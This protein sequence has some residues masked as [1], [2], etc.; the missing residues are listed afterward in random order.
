MRRWR[1]RTRRRCS[2]R[3]A[4]RVRG[5]ASG[6]ASHRCRRNGEIRHTPAAARWLRRRFY[7]AGGCPG[8]AEMAYGTSRSPGRQGSS[9]PALFVALAKQQVS[10]PSPSTGSPARLR[11]W[12]PTTRKTRRSWPRMIPGRAD[13]LAQRSLRTSRGIGGRSGRPSRESKRLARSIIRERWPG[14][15]A[16]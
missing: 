3:C 1:A 9:D 5:C 2:G 10:A 15:A 8:V 11:C 13:P 7:R 6:L 12:S 4:A 14:A 16:W